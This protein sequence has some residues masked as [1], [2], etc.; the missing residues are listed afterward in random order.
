M[1][2]PLVHPSRPV[3][4]QHESSRLF[5]RA[6]AALYDRVMRP[7]ENAGM[8]ARRQALV[9]Q[10]RGRTLEVGAGTGLNL[11]LY[12][13]GLEL[14]LTEPDPDLGKRLRDRAAGRHPV[15]AAHAE[16][17][18]FADASFDC[19]VATLVFCTVPDPRLALAEL[20]RVLRPGGELL[21]LEH[22]RAP[23]GTRRA[24]WQDRLERPWRTLACGCHCNRDTLAVIE[25]APGF[26]LEHL[27]EARWEKAGPVVRPL[28]SARAVKVA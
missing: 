4:P 3:P 26:V 1:S 21:V 13:A 28:I 18:P 11:P 24:R 23:E 16:A 25:A 7:A 5:A 27:E 20:R 14:V 6:F 10:A 8:R 12:P 2:T 9:A 22:V 15:I 19:A 17:L